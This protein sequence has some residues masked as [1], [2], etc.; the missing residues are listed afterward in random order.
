MAGIIGNKPSSEND[1]PAVDAQDFL[2]G[3]G[4][5]ITGMVAGVQLGTA[6]ANEK[7]G[8]ISEAKHHLF[9]ACDN[10]PGCKVKLLREPDPANYPKGSVVTI[11]VTL[12]TF[13]G[14][15]YYTEV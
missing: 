15:I 11:P 9:L 14:I 2:V 10:S 4:L 13:N 5:K 8:V 6:R 1:F 7:T 3:T 12:T